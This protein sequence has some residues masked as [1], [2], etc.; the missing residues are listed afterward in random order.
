MISIIVNKFKMN[1]K[2]L[3]NLKFNLETIFK[4]TLAHE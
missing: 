2:W 1:N 3:F 4:K